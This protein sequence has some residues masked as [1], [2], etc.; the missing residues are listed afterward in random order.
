MNFKKYI[1]ILDWLP[2]YKKAWFKGD[3]EAGLTV[4]IML[5]PQG[6]AYAMIAGL[7]PIYGLYTAMIPQIV[8]AIFGTSRQLAVGPVAMDSLIVAS[9]VAALA[10]IGTE[11][12]IEFA[13]LLAFMMGFLQ[14]V[15]GFF[16]LGFLVNFLSRP[17][18]SGF[19]SAAALIIGL[20]QLKHLLGVQILRDNKIHTLVFDAFQQLREINWLTFAI[21]VSSILI[22]VFLKR[23]T[24]KIPA[25]LVVVV[26]GIVSVRVFQLEQ[27]GV[28]ILGEI[29]KGLP[30]FTIP[31]F[32]KNTLI[33]LF[34]IALT[35]SFIAFL[36]AI[37]V[38]KAIEIRHSN[39]KVN[40]NQELIAIGLGNIVGSFF[41]TYP[42]TGGLSRTAVNNQTGAKTPFAAIISGLIVG[43]TL[44]FLTPVFFYLPKAVLGA[45]IVVAVYGLLDFSMPKELLTYSKRELLILNITLIVT[46]T[47]G[48]K[49][50]IFIGIIL[51]LAMLIYRSTK[52]HFAVLGQV[53]S[54]H[55]YRNINRFEG[56]LK[57]ADDILIVRFD[58]QLYF[59]NVSF[60]KDKLDEFVNEKGSKLKLI[61]IDWES[62]NSVDS[63]GIFMLKDVIN[64]YKNMGVEIAFSGMKGPVRD[65]LDKSKIIKKIDYSNCFMSIQ[66]AVD[67]FEDRKKN[68]EI[69]V[70]Y[71]DFIN[72][73]NG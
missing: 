15:F 16:K 39:Y 51:S 53:R 12:F 21:G 52:P 47:V 69:E 72:Q 9:G 36:E 4:G 58:A 19:T 10:Q 40:P 2:N 49:E 73:T 22:L 5:I 11:N 41:Q 28:Q 63:S 14:V 34:P 44:L 71:F 20:N 7:P 25:A 37:S 38:A 32:E 56:L 64:K 61:I 59:A 57:I 42:A 13:I 3:L 66:E 33:D 24:T 70:K 55:F 30:E 48:I 6:I 1:P 35:L 54:T 17:V 50:G 65:I 18:I 27:F 29:P 62:I 67:A 45:I 31:K 23:L 46:A 68:K 60:F 26:L 43:I 8:Y